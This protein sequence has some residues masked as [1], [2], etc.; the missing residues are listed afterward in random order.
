MKES[1]LRRC[2]SPKFESGQI[3]AVRRSS[4]P[5]KGYNHGLSNREIPC[6]AIDE[7]TY[8]AVLHKMRVVFG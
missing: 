3:T 8:A 6:S 1:G 2:V 4:S 7:D 5:N